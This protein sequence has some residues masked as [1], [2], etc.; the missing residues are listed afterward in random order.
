MNLAEVLS[1]SNLSQGSA[2]FSLTNGV[3]LFAVYF[4]AGGWTLT[5]TDSSNG[6]LTGSASTAAY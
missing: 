3:G 4:G 6:S 1:F 2:S 5:A